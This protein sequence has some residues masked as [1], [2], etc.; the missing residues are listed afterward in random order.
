MAALSLQEHLG[1]FSVTLA[2]TSPLYTLRECLL[3]VGGKNAHTED[4][5]GIL[6]LMV[7]A[8][9]LVV[10]VKCTYSL[11]FAWRIMQV[12]GG[13]SHCSPWCQIGSAPPLSITAVS[14]ELHFLA[15]SGRHCCTEMA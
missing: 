10:T 13:F 7:W 12:K 3:G 1:W 2:V 11:H 15:S 4:V 6:S 14:P 8:L 9:I 5:L